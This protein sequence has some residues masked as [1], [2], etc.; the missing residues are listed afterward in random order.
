MSQ[1]IAILPEIITNKIA[2]GEVVERPASVI[3]ELIENSLDA[4]ATD[5]SVEIAA[6]GR[7]LIRITDNGHGM[8]REDALLSLERHATSKIR[9]DSDLDGIHTLGFRGEAL[10]SI[11]SVSRLRLSSREADSP[12]GTEIIVEGGKVRDVR[13]CGMA[14]GTVISVEQIFFNTPAR[15]KFMRSAETEAGHVGD[16]LTR[17]AISR[18]D[19]AF[20]CSSDGRD[21]LRVQRGDLLRRLSQALGK[22]TAASLHELRLSRDGI[23]ISGYISAPAACRST[24][25]AMFTYINGRFIRDKVIQHAI[26]QAYRGVMDRGRYPVVALFIQL[27]PGEVDVNVHPTKHEVRF[28]RQSLVHDTLQSA[29]EELLKR[30]PWLPR[31][32]APAQ[33]AAASAPSISQAYR[34][35]IAAAAQASLD[36]ARKPDPPRFPGAAKTQPDQQHPPGTESVSV[37]EAPTPFQPREPAVEPQGYFS[38]LRVIGQFHD[39]YILCQSGDQLVI[40]DQHAASERVAFQK[41]RGQ[42]ETGGVESQ[43]LLFPETLELSFSEA[44][45]AR[46]F[47]NEL[48]RIGFE[49]EPFGGNT[50]IVS[51]IPRLTIAQDSSGLVRDL[52]AELTQLGA[53]S[54]FLDARDALLSRIACHSV[55]RGVHRL[56]E[57]QIRELLRGMDATDFAAS[58]PHG[59]PVSHTITLGELEKIFKRT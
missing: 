47:A 13:A 19:V 10:P 49:L 32:Q 58:C 51:A 4:G 54:A 33:P 57:R 55:V 52:L 35:R 26:M 31:P 43:R 20:S 27:P 18:P 46:R 6:G 15:L 2:A 45:T 24:T 53:S 59:R 48:A 50:V 25:S 42:F 28:R 14:P 23:D 12:E 7:R 21:L 11:A 17:M 56:E 36:M 3:K 37:R 44:D 22:G 38:A 34:E 40:I 39:E 41:L 9:S 1:R 16:C 8:S 5:I 30:S 29:L